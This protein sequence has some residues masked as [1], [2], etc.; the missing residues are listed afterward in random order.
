MPPVRQLRAVCACLLLSFSSVTAAFAMAPGTGRLRII[1]LDVGQGDGA[2]LIS[3]GGEVAMFDDGTGGLGTMGVSVP[4]QLQALGV[5]GVEHH[6]ASHY[7]ADHIGGLPAIVSAG[8]PITNGWDRGGSYTA[9]FPAY[10]A[11]L[12]AHRKTIVK[13]QVITLDS[14]SAHPV[15]I[16][17]VDLDGAGISV[18]ATDENSR[19]MVMKVTYGEFD[20]TF[21]G[22]LPGVTGTY[23]DIET[24]IGPETGPVEVY[25]VHHHGSSTSSLDAWLNATT[26]KVAVIS[27]GNGNSYG[28]PTAAALA[29]LHNHGVKTY[30]T[31]TGSGVAPLAGWDKV[32]NGQVVISATWTGAGVDTIRGNGFTDTFINSGTA[33]GDMLPPLAVLLSPDGGETLK[34]GSSQTITWSASDNVAVS[35]VDLAWSADGGGTWNAIATAIANTGTYAWTVPSQATTTGRIRVRARDAAGNLGA[36]SS[37]SAF[38]VDYW[39]VTATAGSGGSVTPAGIVNVVQGAS[40]SFAIAPLTG[41]LVEDVLVDGVSQGALTAWQFTGVTAHHTVEAVFLDYTSPLVTLASPNGG[42]AL[43][44]GNTCAITWTA[45]DN[46][47]VDSV[48]V[49]VTYAGVAGPWFA[50]AH[51]LPNTGTWNWTVPDLPT[52]SARV[53]VTAMDRTHNSGAAVSDGAFVIG[54]SSA[55]VGD[56]GPV[57]LALAPPAPNP[58]M[59]AVS[60]RYSLPVAGGA[61]IEV[62]DML[63]RRVGQY[64]GEFAAGTHSWTWDGRTAGGSRA[65]AGLYM[66]RL[67]T[68]QGTRTQR[69]VLLR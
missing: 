40:P 2:V 19:S 42:E 24:T 41:C 27:C 7:H 8:I 18:G 17:C 59:G 51:G 69:L 33:P 21:G 66:V 61:R 45:T 56:G 65:G 49:D 16:K 37:A 15:L 55:G 32:S 23:K 62:L 14:L 47:G 30:W 64:A 9:S 10:A 52:D 54:T 20:M 1:H 6:F 3:P 39:T 5:T 38:T 44:P 63:G 26:P 4:A 43:V 35:S 50:L 25:K 57:L 46:V 67:H 13:N 48:N 34:A 60:L 31:E 36:D 22:D 28:H 29:R 58:A 11:A 12:G 68:A 53:R